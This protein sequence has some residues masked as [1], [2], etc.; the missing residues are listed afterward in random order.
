MQYGKLVDSQLIPLRQPLKINGLDTYT[1]DAAVILA[2]GWKPV[3]YIEPPKQEGY[4]AVAEWMETEDAITQV[5]TLHEAPEP[6]PDPYEIIDTLTGE[7][8]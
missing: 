3:V 1:N 2:Q 8:E 6:D 7:V 4:Y 5:W